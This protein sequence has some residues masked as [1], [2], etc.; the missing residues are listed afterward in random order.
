MRD[1]VGVGDGGCCGTVGLFG[2]ED[3]GQ[4]QDQGDDHAQNAVELGTLGTA[5]GEAPYY[6]KDYCQDYY[7]CSDADSEGRAAC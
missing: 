7:E 1:K 4:D 3:E 6:A 2:H 5:A